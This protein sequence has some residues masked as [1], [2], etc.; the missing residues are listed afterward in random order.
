M[1]DDF[2]QRSRPAYDA[3]AE[4]YMGVAMFVTTQGFEEL[5][6]KAIGGT[7]GRYWRGV[8]LAN[9]APWY[10]VTFRQEAHGFSWP[11]TVLVTWETTLL[12]VLDSATANAVLSIHGLGPNPAR[13]GA[14][15]TL[16]IV[17]LWRPAGG[18]ADETGPLLFRFA[19]E[20]GLRDSFDGAALAPLTGRDL[21]FRVSTAGVRG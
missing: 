14:W 1:A 15:L 11:Q 2:A 5:V 13:E 3:F 4:N 17:E 19:G 20:G 18:E 10:V 16:E 7:D 6:P 8:M 9:N 12:S 21:L